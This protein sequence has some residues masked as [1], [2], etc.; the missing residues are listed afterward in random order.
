MIDYTK[1]GKVAIFRINRPKAMGALSVEGLQNFQDALID[2][3]DDDAL[4]VGIVTGTGSK[5]FCAGADVKELLAHVSETKHTKWRRSANIMRGLD[6]WKP[7]IAACNGLTLGAGLELSLACDI[8]IASENAEFGLPEVKLGLIPGAGG[9]TR[10]PKT[11]PKRI[12]AEMLFTG[13]TISAQEAYRVGLINK[14]VP[15]D[16]LME[17][18]LKLAHTICKNAPLA[19]RYAK[20]LMFRGTGLSNEEMLRLEDDIDSI[21][22]STED[23]SEGVTAFVEKRIPNYKGR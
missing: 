18:A 4:W 2:F 16:Q 9:T 15:L 17:E 1:E 10:L 23:F 22:L 11:I 3:R 21:V 20:E 14:I 13:E 8:M 12:A 7:M 6:L 19:V 5:V